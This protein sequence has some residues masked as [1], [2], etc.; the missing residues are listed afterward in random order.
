M[1]CV[2]KTG[3]AAIARLTAFIIII[4]FGCDNN[5]GKAEM[6]GKLNELLKAAVES[7]DEKYVALRKEIIAGRGDIV[8]ELR[9]KISDPDWRI[10]LQAEICLAW[11]G[12]PKQAEYIRRL[13]EGR[14][15]SLEPQKYLT[16]KPPMEKVIEKINQVGPAAAPI[17]IEMIYKEP[18]A[19]TDYAFTAIDLILTEWQ[20]SRAINVFRE[21]MLDSE[22]KTAFRLMAMSPLV[23]LKAENLYDDLL[24]IF[25]N[26]ENPQDLRESA[27]TVI[28]STGDDRAIPFLEQFLLDTNLQSE[29]RQAA[30]AGLGETQSN[31]VL[32]ILL[33]QYDKTSDLDLREAIL[34]ALGDIE[35]IETL[36]SLRQLREI[37]K[38]EGLRELIDNN[39]ESLEYL[40]E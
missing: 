28:G 26:T 8:S 25:E 30:A 14:D 32:S 27:L 37:E 39:I 40:E 13:A 2:T 11:R 4:I 20:D 3:I 16:H 31:A 9:D 7:R 10:G 21:I 19:T 23:E 17:L 36:K 29:F 24:K 1:R 15:E 33:S 34:F 18:A 38:D 6:N 35:T 12:D 22:M 5:K